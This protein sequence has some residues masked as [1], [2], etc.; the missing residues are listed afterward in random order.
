MF[1]SLFSFK[2]L[3]W[4]DTCRACACSHSLCTFVCAAVLLCLEGIVSLVFP[5]VIILFLP[6][7]TQSSLNLKERF[8]RDITF[9]AKCS[10]VI[11]F[12]T[13]CSTF[14]VSSYESLDLFPSKLFWLWLSKAL[15]YEC[16]RISLEVIL[17]LRSFAEQLYRH[18][19][20]WVV[21]GFP[22]GPF[23]Q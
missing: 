20:A 1:I 2:D 22:G 18:Q 11:P 3:F 16:N 23:C 4:F 12:R 9:R 7:N 21:W 17:L 14:T 8:D 13:K 10:K 19:I 15:I 5:L 6:P